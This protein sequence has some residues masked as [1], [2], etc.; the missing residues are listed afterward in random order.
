[1][2]AKHRRS[3]HISKPWLARLCRAVAVLGLCFSSTLHALTIGHSR[4]ESTADEN[5][6][7]SVLISGVSSQDL[8]QLDVQVAPRDAWSEFGLKPL[9]EVLNARVQL[10]PGPRP[11]SVQV[12]FL[13]AAPVE[14]SIIDL[15]FDVRT[16]DEEQRHQVSMLQQ[17]GPS[18]QLPVEQ[19][20]TLTTVQPSSSKV[21]G[22][23]LLV[24]P[25]D[26]LHRIAQ[27]L[28]VQHGSEYQLLA[29]LYQL[30]PQAFGQNNM[31]LLFAG[32]QLRM[33]TAEQ[34][35]SMSDQQAR[36]LY[37]EHMHRF[38]QYKE[39]LARGASKQEATVLL[40]DSAQA[41][42]LVAAEPV[43][44]TQSEASEAVQKAE[45]LDEHADRLRLDE[46][47]ASQAGKIRADE[48]Q[49]QEKALAYVRQE[50]EKLEAEIDT[51]SD[52]L[53]DDL[54]QYPD[55]HS[56]L[57]SPE[58]EPTGFDS[59]ATAKE[60]TTSLNA[61][62]P[63]HADFDKSTGS[64][65][66]STSTLTNTE[67]A[68]AFAPSAQGSGQY[69]SAESSGTERLNSKK[70]GENALASPNVA[71]QQN[72][73]ME[74]SWIQNHFIKL[75]LALLAFVVIFTVWILRRANKTTVELESPDRVTDEMIRAKLQ[76]INLDL[77]VPPID[78]S[79]E[80]RRSDKS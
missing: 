26:S 56:G 19:S 27:R 15:L 48:R 39:A 50:V 2:S 25:G 20:K 75:M 63:T 5:L 60:G 41:Q 44:N 40:N 47:G 3:Q 42:A 54:E 69:T 76:D 7:L 57:G 49:A 53:K 45:Y 64:S 65:S 68:G 79:G 61:K 38:N 14:Q 22:E 58:I 30:N 33:P 32:E 10:A 66:P 1:M 6:Q 73:D 62:P 8:D 43:S 28:G 52:A 12:R 78:E 18:I 70:P 16:A 13:S 51:L 21:Y 31:H 72:T 17:P 37:V 24:Q 9:P 46:S 74:I 55:A 29:A 71:V 36:H 11:N 67:G 34:I 23:S 80:T 4:V 59:T 35:Q 77:E